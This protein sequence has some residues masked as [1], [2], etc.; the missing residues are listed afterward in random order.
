MN[1]YQ[2]ILHTDKGEIEIRL[3]G[4]QTPKTVQNFVD[5]AR[6][7]FYDN[8]VFHRV[9]KDFMI[10]GGC[11][12]G[13]GTGGPGYRFDDEP[14]TGEYVRGAVAMA[15]AGPNTNGSQFF[16]MHAQVPLPKNYVIFGQ[17]TQGLEV[18]DAIAESPVTGSGFGEKSKPVQPVVV[19]SVEIKEV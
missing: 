18:V 4:E 8:T 12:Q 16:I 15:N 2:A 1:N 9:I 11:P 7:H 13:N 10:Q 14:F 19:K 17:V 5:L 6:K 3:Q